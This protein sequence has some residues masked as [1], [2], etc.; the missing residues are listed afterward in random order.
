[1]ALFGTVWLFV[2]PFDW[3]Y[4]WFMTGFTEFSTSFTEFSTSFTE[5]DLRID[6]D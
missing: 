2:R 5:F 1:M 3:F 6:L 4:D